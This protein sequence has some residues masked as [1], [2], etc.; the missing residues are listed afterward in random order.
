MEHIATLFGERRLPPKKTKRT[1]RGDLLEWF[2]VELNHDR[3][4]VKY[5]KLT[6]GRMSYLLQHLNVR[7]LYYMKSVMI[8]TQ[9]RGGNGSK[10]FWWS[11][12][13]DTMK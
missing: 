8:D 5:K 10:Y 3:D 12:K 9:R 6:V 11:L 7:D 2:A 13:S 4:G 1:E